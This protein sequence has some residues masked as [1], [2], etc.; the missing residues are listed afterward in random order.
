MRL[1]RLGSLHQSRLSFMRILT[2]RMARDSWRFSQ[3]VFDIDSAGVGHA[4]YTA[5]TPDRDYSLV[6]FAHDLPASQ[7]SDRVIAEAW[8]ATFCLFDGVP[9]STDIERLAQNVPL[10][11]SYTHLT[12]PTKA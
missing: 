8:D 7:R 12:L 6:A 2:R 4:V 11:V 10:P 3:P 1:K 9:D 5:H